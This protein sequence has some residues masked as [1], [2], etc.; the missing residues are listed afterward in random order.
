MIV[1]TYI[2]V[3]V[4]T[5]PYNKFRIHLSNLHL[6][7]NPLI[8]LAPGCA[9]VYFLYRWIWYDVSSTI[10]LN[11]RNSSET[12]CLIK[13]LACPELISQ[14]P[15]VLKVCSGHDSDTTVVNVNVCNDWTKATVGI[16]EQVLQNLDQVMMSSSNGNIFRVTGPFWVQSTGHQGIFLSKAC[17]A[18]LWCFLWSAPEQTV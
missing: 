9:Y 10:L 8:I 1:K 4:I 6:L 18:E 5:Y 17:E 12:P 14:L 13:I 11:I 15:I 7:N 3:T 2:C 16:D